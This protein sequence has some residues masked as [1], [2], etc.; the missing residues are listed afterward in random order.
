MQVPMEV[1][2]YFSKEAERKTR[3]QFLIVLQCAPIL[4]EVKPS[5]LFAV[6][7]REGQEAAKI[8]KSYGIETKIIGNKTGRELLFCYRNKQLNKLLYEKSRQTFLSEMGY[9][10]ANTLES[11]LIFWKKRMEKYQ[12]GSAVFPHET[13][14]FL[15]YPVGD[16]Q[17][18]MQHQGKNA[19]DE[20]YWKV[21]ENLLQARLTFSLY[22]KTKVF[23]VNR[24]L[25]GKMIEQR[26]LL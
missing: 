10:E 9:S 3:L 6:K 25:S 8:L 5:V 23:S 14:I 15:G 26:E 13:G 20:D 4:S 16:V 11:K 12:E 2:R 1:I 19:T 24:F 22:D 7:A 17:G 18:F 21:Y